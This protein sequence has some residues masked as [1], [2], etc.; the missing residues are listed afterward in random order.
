MPITSQTEV[1]SALEQISSLMK[2][3][4]DFVESDND[5]PFSMDT[6]KMYD[7]IQKF[8]SFMIDSFK[9]IDRLKNLFERVRECQA[10]DVRSLDRTPFSFS[11]NDFNT[12]EH[13][14][15]SPHVI[16]NLNNM[17]EYVN[18]PRVTRCNADREPIR[19]WLAHAFSLT[20]KSLTRTKC[21]QLY[22]TL[23]TN[24]M[25]PYK[26]LVTPEFY[27]TAHEIICDIFRGLGFGDSY[28]DFRKN[29]IKL[30]MIND[31]LTA[32]T[33]NNDKTVVDE[34]VQKLTHIDVDLNS[35]KPEDDEECA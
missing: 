32:V 2:D 19:V 33:S 24:F 18:A 5:K 29:I 22:N 31:V 30:K 27:K 12:K 26:S 23:D 17:R 35:I 11:W 4:K 1:S 8:H 28:D 21:E 15:L 9:K 6:L 16:D 25:E 34:A 14:L 10:I 13:Y 20:E 7:E 3:L